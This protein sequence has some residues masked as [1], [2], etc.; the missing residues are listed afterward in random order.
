MGTGGL[1]GQEKRGAK[2]CKQD[3]KNRQNPMRACSLIDTNKPCLLTRGWHVRRT[4]LKN[5]PRH[6]F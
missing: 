1:A 6:F 3:A 5:S 4:L 2:Y